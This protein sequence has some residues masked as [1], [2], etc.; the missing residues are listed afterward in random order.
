MLKGI[1]ECLSENNGC[2]LVFTKGRVRYGYN[3]G[4]LT[5]APNWLK[6]GVGEQ[7][8]KLSCLALGHDIVGPV[9]AFVDGQEVNFFGRCCYCGKE[10]R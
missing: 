8:A 6:Y 10:F 3:Y 4:H 5:W 9:K 1:R 2:G 7:Y